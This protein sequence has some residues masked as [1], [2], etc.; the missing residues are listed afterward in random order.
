MIL[1]IG[2]Y[3]FYRFYKISIDNGID[4]IGWAANIVSAYYL[5]TIIDVINLF[6]IFA[7]LEGSLAVGYI[8]LIAV[9]VI[10]YNWWRYDK[11]VSLESL[12]GR[13]VNEDGNRRKYRFLIMM[14]YLGLIFLGPFVIGFFR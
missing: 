11:I 3:I 7:N 12:H 13:W 9:P 6:R 10:G 2:D 5:L 8:W 1:T 4:R 14:I